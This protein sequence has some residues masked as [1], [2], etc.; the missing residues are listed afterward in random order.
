MRP[1]GDVT[2]KDDIWGRD[3]CDILGRGMEFGTAYVDEI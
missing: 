3:T 2:F 1:F